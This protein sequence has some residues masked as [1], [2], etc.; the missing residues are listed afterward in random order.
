MFGSHLPIPG[1][2]AG[3]LEADYFGEAADGLNSF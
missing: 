3:K 2:S 1:L